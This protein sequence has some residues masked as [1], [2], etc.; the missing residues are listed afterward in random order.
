MSRVKAAVELD[1]NTHIQVRQVGS[2]VYVEAGDCELNVESVQVATDMVDAF[3]DV[4]RRLN[5]IE[6]G[7]RH[8]S[9]PG[10]E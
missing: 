8:A 7:K 10:V 9:L 1:T 3:V 6:V 2:Q 4:A 5:A